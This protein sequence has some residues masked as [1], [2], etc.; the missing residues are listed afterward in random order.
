MFVS[1]CCL[2]VECLISNLSTRFF[3]LL[4]LFD[5]IPLN[6]I[7]KRVTDKQNLKKYLLDSERSDFYDYV[8]FLIIFFFYAYNQK[9]YKN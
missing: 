3:I 4:I 7:G 6:K 9:F 8:F 5:S 1:V 2:S